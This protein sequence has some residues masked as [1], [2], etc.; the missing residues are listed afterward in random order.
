MTSSADLSTTEWVG[1]H[2]GVSVSIAATTN[3]T[4]KDSGYVYISK[5]ENGYPEIRPA[6]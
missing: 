3:F 4:S 2:V 6:Q 5:E 1:K